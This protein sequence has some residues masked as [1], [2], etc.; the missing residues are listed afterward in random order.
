M[1][2]RS[3]RINPHCILLGSFINR[4]LSLALCKRI[5]LQNQTVRVRCKAPVSFLKTR[6]ETPLDDETELPITSPFTID[7]R[8]FLFSCIR[9]SV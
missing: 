8:L 3:G 2:A 4:T 9:N 7:M 6:D 5:L 1:T